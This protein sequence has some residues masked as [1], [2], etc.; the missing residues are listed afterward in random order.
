MSEVSKPY[1]YARKE[2]REV[3]MELIDELFQNL[4]GMLGSKLITFY[5]EPYVAGFKTL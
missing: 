2:T 3:W 4:I 1:R 5:S